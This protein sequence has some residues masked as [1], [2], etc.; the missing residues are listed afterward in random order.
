M[1]VVCRSSTEIGKRVQSW[2]WLV[3]AARWSFFLAW[4]GLEAVPETQCFISTSTHHGRF[5]RRHGQVKNS[6]FVPRQ[7]GHFV[8]RRI[9]P[10]LQRV[11]RESV[12]SDDFRV[13]RVP[14]NAGNLALGVNGVAALARIHVP[15]TNGAIRSTASGSQKSALPRAPG[16]SLD[17]G[18]VLTE[19]KN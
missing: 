1:R 4:V 14:E 2:T 19:V 12:R 13:F 17:C 5:S 3:F 11:V 16:H 8:H 15:D 9:F 6:G 7:F 10:D 18:L